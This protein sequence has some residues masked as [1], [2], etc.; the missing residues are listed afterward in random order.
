MY[1]R[2]KSFI[3]YEICKVFFQLRAGTE[4]GMS[5]LLNGKAQSPCVVSADTTERDITHYH[6][7]RVKIGPGV[8]L[9]ISDT[10]AWMLGCLVII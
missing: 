9:A 2:Y 8:L 3:G 1:V 10:L 6:P 7:S 4:R 5:L